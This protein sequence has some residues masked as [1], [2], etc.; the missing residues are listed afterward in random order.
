MVMKEFDEMSG[1]EKAAALLVALGTGVAS[2][3]L[4]YLDDESIAKIS[5]GIAKIEKL[6]AEEREN[7]IGE[8]LLQLKKRR[9]EA[10]GGE[11]TAKNLLVTALGEEKAGEILKKLSHRNLEKGFEFL[12]EIDSE[13]LAG[14]IQKEHPQTI[15]VTLA[16]LPAQKAAQL[17]QKLPPD[18]AKDAARRMARMDKTSP[19]AILEIAR[20][21]RK[22]YEAVKS[23]GHDFVTPG[24]V[25]KLADIMNYM[26]GDQE[27]RLMDHFEDS[28]PDVAQEI[29]DRIFTFENTATLSNQEMRLLIDELGDDMLVVRALKG[30]GDE[31]RF[32]FL[33]NMSRNRATDILNEIDLIGPLRVSEIQYARDQVVAVM[34]ELNERGLIVLRKTK[35]GMID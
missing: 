30:A 9:F 10:V 6:S 8:F 29:R 27:K 26:S 22:K 15:A 28:I 11:S 13:I 25:G 2:E 17:M 14:M 3:I 24:G 1:T 4:R 34:R 12:N 20:V 19:E 32:K 31:I 18:V 33:R 16:H 7:L 35:E 23:A 21:I 5:E